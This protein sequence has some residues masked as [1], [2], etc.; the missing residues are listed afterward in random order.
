MSYQP[1]KAQKG[2]SMTE[3]KPYRGFMIKDGKHSNIAEG[4]FA[5]LIGAEDVV[6]PAL[7]IGAEWYGCACSKKNLN[8]NGM[9]TEET[10]V[11]EKFRIFNYS[12]SP[13]RVTSLIDGPCILYRNEGLD[14][15]EV[16]YLT[17]HGLYVGSSW[18][19]IS[20]FYDGMMYEYWDP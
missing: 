17:D 19:L 20:L 4:D 14:H 9:P 15:D 1:I 11:I 10:S 12:N 8:K 18:M 13:I 16:R 5:E 3:E 6:T 7:R 2:D